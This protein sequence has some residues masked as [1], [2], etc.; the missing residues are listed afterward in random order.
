MCLVSRCDAGGRDGSQVRRVRVVKCRA[1]AATSTRLSL[2]I[3]KFQTLEIG[4]CCARQ[5]E[6][7][8]RPYRIRHMR[9][10]GRGTSVVAVHPWR[11]RQGLSARLMLG[12]QRLAVSP[13]ESHAR[14]RRPAGSVAQMRVGSMR[15]DKGLRL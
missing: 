4:N 14:A 5:G 7:N 1:R 6:G 11:R 2:W 3:Q 10:K 9:R 12:R 13:V 15:G 8:E